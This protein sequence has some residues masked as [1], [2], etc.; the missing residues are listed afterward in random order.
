MC[1]LCEAASG[2]SESN[3][4]SV[5][6]QCQQDMWMEVKAFSLTLIRISQCQSDRTCRIVQLLLPQW[7]E[8]IDAGGTAQR[9]Q[10]DKYHSCFGPL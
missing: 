7:K 9:L 3:I 10:R 1:G 4:N 2:L 8:D 6:D 5:S